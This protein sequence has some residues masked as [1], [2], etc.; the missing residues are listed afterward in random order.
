MTTI[1]VKGLKE[2]QRFLDQL[3][4]K[5]E[6]NILRSALRAA[7]KPIAESARQS[8]PVGEP[9]DTAKRRYR[10]YAGALRDSIRISSRID[11]R[12]SNVTASV[13]AGGKV[14]KTGADVFYANFLEFGTNPHGGG[15]QNPGIAPQPFM[16]PAIDSQAEA[17]VTA[18][19]EY[20]KRR[21]AAKHGLNTADIEIGIEEE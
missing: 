13:K 18:A 5:I 12:N 1:N 17:A 21:L 14:R 16:R 19:G 20:I 9:S 8:A 10:V 4:A 7:A 2:L 11:R 3:P 15:S 6:A